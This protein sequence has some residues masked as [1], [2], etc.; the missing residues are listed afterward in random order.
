MKLQYALTLHNVF[1]YFSRAPFLQE[2]GK[3]Q[4][5]STPFALKD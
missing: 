2:K 3:F 5:E 4:I 1:S